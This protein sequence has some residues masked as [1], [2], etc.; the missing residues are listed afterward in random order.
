MQRNRFWLFLL[1]P[2]LVLLMA[3][4]QAPL[5]NPDPIAI[6]A[7]ITDTQVSKAVKQALVARGWSVAEEKAG[8]IKATLHLRDHV[9]R[10]DI[11]WDKRQIH[12]TYLG[13]ENLKYEEKGGT[14]YIHKNYLGW[15]QNLVTDINGNL[16]LL[17]S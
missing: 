2:I 4:R 11:T 13:S 9:A 16:V 10:I 5:V 1:L 14:R 6:P 12:I 15:I 7:G 8:D 17:S 3:A